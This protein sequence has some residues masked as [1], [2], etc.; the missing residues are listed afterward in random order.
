MEEKTREVEDKK[1]LRKNGR[2][3]KEKKGRRKVVDALRVRRK[4]GS[5]NKLEES[6]VFVHLLRFA[7]NRLSERP[8]IFP[9]LVGLPVGLRRTFGQMALPS[10]KKKKN[11]YYRPNIR[12]KKT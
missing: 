3:S 9:E 4:T 5:A 8:R 1:Q 2:E 7:S 6:R 12:R 10:Y 11:K